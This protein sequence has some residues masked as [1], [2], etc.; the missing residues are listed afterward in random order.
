M[1]CKFCGENVEGWPV[2]DVI[3]HTRVCEEEYVKL[4]CAFGYVYMIR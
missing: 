3:N 2:E 1:N 4:N